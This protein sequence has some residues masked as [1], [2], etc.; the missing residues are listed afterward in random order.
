MKRKTKENAKDIT[1]VILKI[2]GMASGLTLVSMLSGGRN[3]DKLFKGLLKFSRWQILKTLKKLRLRG[4]VEFDLED[5]KAPIV[6]TE[7]GLKRA[8]H[9]RLPDLFSRRPRRWDYLWRMVIFDVPEKKRGVRDAFRRELN[10]IG[11]YQLQKS[12][13]VSPHKCEKEIIALARTYRALSHMLILTVASLGPLEK[14]VRRN[15]FD[16]A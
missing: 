1:A 5:E 11:F 4:Y 15:F 9:Y 3:S 8:L 7:N 10:C 6:L 14:K 12:V 16:K 2:L 13:F